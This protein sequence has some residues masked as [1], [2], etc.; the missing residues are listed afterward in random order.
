M[1]NLCAHRGPPPSRPRVLTRTRARAGESVGRP[2]S[3]YAELLRWARVGRSAR[4]CTRLLSSCSSCSRCDRSRAPAPSLP[5]SSLEGLLHLPHRSPTGPAV[6]PRPHSR[7]PGVTH[8][9]KACLPAPHSLKLPS[10]LPVDPTQASRNTPSSHARPGISQAGIFLS[11]CNLLHTL[12]ASPTGVCMLG[13]GEEEALAAEPAGHGNQIVCR[14]HSCQVP[15]APEVNF[16][17]AKLGS[18]QYAYVK[19]RLVEHVE[20]HWGQQWLSRAHFLI[21]HVPSS[22]TAASAPDEDTTPTC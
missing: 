22:T 4:R 7:V 2:P 20:T 16:C 11:F 9:A 21:Q 19:Q 14:A 18:S 6:E 10:S 12:R 5:P 1:V 3:R 15:L 8:G 13:S 17:A